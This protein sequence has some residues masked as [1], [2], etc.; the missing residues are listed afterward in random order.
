MYVCVLHTYG[1]PGR[2]R[3]FLD[4]Q[5]LLTEGC[6]AQHGHW[7]LKPE[8]RFSAEKVS[9][10][11]SKTISPALTYDAEDIFFIPLLDFTSKK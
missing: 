10:L 4:P 7:E 3:G 11:K 8:G 6:E 2:S 5:E 1:R 9:D